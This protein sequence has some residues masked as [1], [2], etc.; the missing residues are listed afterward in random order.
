MK[1]GLNRIRNED[2]NKSVNVRV[3]YTVEI[4]QEISWP[5]D[6]LEHLNYDN[7]LCNLDTDDPTS[8]KLLGDILDVKVDGVDFEF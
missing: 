8:Q 3:K 7:L 6:E 5:K 4:I 1:H 2:H